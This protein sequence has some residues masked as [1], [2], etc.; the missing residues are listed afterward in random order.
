VAAPAAKIEAMYDPAQFGLS[1]MQRLS[2][3]PGVDEE[4]AGK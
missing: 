4:V 3:L 1:P 2:T